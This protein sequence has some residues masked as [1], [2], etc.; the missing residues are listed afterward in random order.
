MDDASQLE[1]CFAPPKPRWAADPL[2]TLNEVRTLAS[3][4]DDS[5]SWNLLRKR[6]DEIA[7]LLDDLSPA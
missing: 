3:D 5:A 7:E 4:V 6:L 1:L 2:A